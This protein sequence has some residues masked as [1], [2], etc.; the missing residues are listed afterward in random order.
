MKNKGQ[1]F[2]T[3]M[4]FALI[5]V[6]ALLSIS[7]QAYGIAS[8]GMRS[9]STRYSLE[10]MTND[11]A[12]VLVKTAGDPIDWEIQAENLETLGLAKIGRENKARRNTLDMHKFS[13]LGNKIKEEPIDESIKEFFGNSTKFDLKTRSDENIFTHIW[14]GWGSED[15]PGAEN[16]LE[17]ATV[18][19]IVYG[20]PIDVRV[21]TPPR[22]PPEPPV[23]VLD[24][25]NFWI[26]P[27]ELEAW[28]W[29][30]YVEN[31]MPPSPNPPNVRITIN[32]DP[33]SAGLGDFN[34]GPGKRDVPGY[35]WLEDEGEI[36]VGEQLEENSW[37]FISIA[38]EAPQTEYK[39]YVV[40]LPPD[41][42]PEN[43]PE[44]L[45]RRPLILRVRVWR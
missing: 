7:T 10:R 30:V 13:Q 27:N 38:A 45:E 15:S 1:V 21:E 28:D 31:T 43:I 42:D 19:R 32:S 24:N 33:S 40:V 35:A 20:R 34:F 17:I 6:A 5:L 23:A 29:Y 14:P 3:D 39:V 41:E 36:T 25:E 22:E 4:I 9:H 8:E 16:S 18:N 11:V 37:N 26:G 2:T 12:D 44:M